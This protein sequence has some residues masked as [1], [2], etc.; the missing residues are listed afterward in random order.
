M[1]IASILLALLV[2]TA[3]SQ[4]A[5]QHYDAVVFASAIQPHINNRTCS[6][7]KRL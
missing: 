1:R 3:V 6:L 5:A 7:C 4:A 2:I